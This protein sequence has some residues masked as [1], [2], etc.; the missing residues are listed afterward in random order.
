MNVLLHDLSASDVSQ[1][2]S[3]SDPS[4]Y[5]I[6][7]PTQKAPVKCLGCFGCWIKT[8]G[9][10]VIKDGFNHMGEYLGNCD[11]F[12]II[13]QSRYG[14][15]SCFTKNILDRSISTVHPYFSKR[16]GEIH[17]K[18]RYNNHPKLQVICYSSDLTTEEKDAFEKRI[19][20]ASINLGCSSSSVTFL[21]GLHET[22]SL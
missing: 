20:A 21:N 1:Y 22:I 5:Q 18:L 14:E 19:K 9:E 17:H 6:V 3:I 13:T 15:F 2:L 4:S 16:N 11:T 7:G 12:T 8:P 10:C